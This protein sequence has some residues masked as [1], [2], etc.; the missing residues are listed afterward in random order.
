MALAA[1]L[2]ALFPFSG[3][4]DY[5]GC[6]ACHAPSVGTCNGCHAHGTH[7]SQAMNDINIAGTT[8]AASYSPAATV[9]ITVGGGWQGGWVRVLLLDENLSEL[10]RSTCPGG[11]GGCTTS[12]FPVTLTAPAPSSSGSH[13][14]AVAWYGNQSDMSGA[15]FGKGTSST[16]KV[17]YFTRIRTIPTTA[18]RPW[19]SRPSRSLRPGALP[20]RPAGHRAGVAAAGGARRG[21]QGSPPSSSCSVGSFAA[22]REVAGQ[23]RAGSPAHS[24]SKEGPAMPLLQ[25][26]KASAGAGVRYSRPRSRR[27]PSRMVI[28]CGGQ[29]GM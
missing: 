4:A 16:L 26:A 19:R 21:S 28:G 8:D 9:T 23:A 5:S 17:G 20:K 25:V 13:T 11:K 2:L 29:P 22:L 14:W 24:F 12:V 27:S 6:E 3:K 15:S 7:S 1:A 18:T 10:A